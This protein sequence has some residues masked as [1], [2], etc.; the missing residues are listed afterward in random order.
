M[1]RPRASAVGEL[2][3]TEEKST[4]AGTT[5]VKFGLLAWNGKYL[6]SEDP[7]KGAVATGTK[8]FLT[9]LYLPRDVCIS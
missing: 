2:S 8:K 3:G 7:L 4:V 9:T 5:E 6:V 1:R